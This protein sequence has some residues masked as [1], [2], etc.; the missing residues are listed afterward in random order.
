MRITYQGEPQGNLVIETDT[1]TSILQTSLQNNIPHTHVCGGNARC[2][3]CRVLVL[4]GLEHCRQR[5]EK[6]QKMATRL[7]FSQNIRLSCQTTLTG[8]ITVRRLVLDDEDKEIVDSEFNDGKERCAGEEKPVAVLFADIRGFTTFAESHLPYDVVHILN[9]YFN[10]VVPIINY[11]GGQ[12]DNF[13]GDGLMALFG[14]QESDD[15]TLRAVR[16]GL[17][18][19]GEVRAMQPY[20]R[21][22]FHMDFR[23]GVGIHYGTVVLGTVG[24]GE[25]RRLTAIGDTVNFASR[26]ESANKDAGTEILISQGAYDQVSSAI[27]IGNYYDFPIKGKTGSYGLYEVLSVLDNPH[28]HVERHEL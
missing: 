23:I 27:S 17:G 7:H 22:H 21:A 10:R 8:D 12:V 1:N 18:M 26:I 5:N 11:H 25:R 13:I 9:R 2:S 28:G 3:T 4:N 15:A 14:V 6:E 20:V 19:L 24:A 16:A